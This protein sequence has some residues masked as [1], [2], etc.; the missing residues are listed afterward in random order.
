MADSQGKTILHINFADIVDQP[1]SLTGATKHR[2]RFI[3]GDALAHNSII[4][5]LEFETLPTSPYAV[6]SYVWRGLPPLPNETSTLP[7]INVKGAEGA[8]PIS[9]EVLK[10][11]SLAAERQ[12][13][14][15]I[16]LDALCILQDDDD[17]KAWQI[18]RMYDI[19]RSSTDCIV[20]PGGLQR[21]VSLTE[22]TTWASRA[23]T[24]Q[25]AIAPPSVHCLFAWDRG[26]CYFQSNFPLP[27]VQL[28]NTK[29]A[30]APLKSA[31]EMSMKGSV[32]LYDMKGKQMDLPS[33]D[34]RIMLFGDSRRDRP[35]IRE[36]IDAMDMKGKTGMF[37][38]IWR[39]SFMRAAKYPVD[40]VFSIMGIMG[41]TLDTSKF[42]LEDR[43]G[44]TIA[45]M[46]AI[47]ARGG[48]AEWLG[49]ATKAL[50]NPKLSTLPVFPQV[51]AAK[52]PILET[53]DG[54]K[55]IADI[56]DTGWR[57]ENTP[58]GVMEDDGH[59]R[60]SAFSTSVRRTKEEGE[61]AT[62]FRS[63][64]LGNWEVVEKEEGSHTAV[65]IGK[66]EQ[67]NNGAFGVLQNPW[68]QALMILEEGGGGRFSNVGY[69][70]VK[71]EVV[72]TGNWEE[73]TVVVGG[74][75]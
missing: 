18:Q 53:K 35:R 10:I 7:K 41:V 49:I 9:V 74:P 51:D 57:L 43:L 26:S 36:L 2:F 16:W 58:V 64:T 12:G 52:R 29:A 32:G 42:G 67:Y 14:K 11:V 63:E 71:E 15:L 75:N 38:A 13:C 56:M 69:A 19:Y 6:I 8:D 72:K 59:F 17:D 31:L 44:A 30:V 21:L 50:P 33:E 37:T 34:Y 23:W 68:D 25:E 65:L 61:S 45:L 55:D 24:L 20:A 5:V 27:V 1:L 73:R 66:W 40:T 3:D 70:F 28:E 60:F 39:S 62:V 4:H 47:L 54:M 48:R 22:E 46:R